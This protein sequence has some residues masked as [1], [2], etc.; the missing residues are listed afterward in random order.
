LSGLAAAAIVAM[1]RAVGET[2]VVAIAAGS[3]P[4]NFNSWGEAL[5]N[6]NF[7]NPFKAAETMTGHIVRISGGDLTYESIQ[8]DS[9]FAIALTLFIMTLI[10]NLISRW[11]VRRFRQEY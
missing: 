3:G 5:N 10:L 9:I 6:F 2:M 11:I 1:S 8:Y 7:L 4:R